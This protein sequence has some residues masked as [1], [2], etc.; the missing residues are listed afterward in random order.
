MTRINRRLFVQSTAAF[1]GLDLLR[2]PSALAADGTLTIAL[3]NN[4]STLDPIQTSNHDAMAISN[5]IF[6]NLLE[7]DLDGNIVPSLARKLPEINDDA[8]RFAFDLRDDVVFQNGQKFTAEDVKYSYEYMLDPKNRSIRR[9]L[10]SPIKEI[11][12]ESPTRVVFNLSGPYRPWL[13]YM[14]KFM[15]V[16]PKGSREAKGDDTFKS[17]PV[18]LGTGPGI[19]V[20]WQPDTQLELRRNPNYWRKGVP[21]WSRVVAKI[22]PDDATRLAYLMTKQADIISS[23]PPRDFDRLKST[24]GIQTGSKVAIGGMWFMQTNTKRAPFDDVNFRKAVS[25]AIDRRAFIDG[26]QAGLGTPIGSHFSPMDLGYLD[27][28]KVYPYDPAKARALLLEAGITAPLEVTLALPPPEYARRGGPLIAAQLAQVG[29]RAK[30]E[31]MEWDQWLAGPFKGNFDLTLINH[32]EPLDYATAY[33]NPDYYFGYDSA[34]IRGYAATLLAVPKMS[35]KGVLWRD[36]QRQ[37]TEDAV[38]VFIWNPAQVSVSRRGLRG[39][40]SSSPIIVNDM[41][42]VSWAPPPTK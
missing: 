5:A 8:T 27:L 33:A 34:K 19:F 39:L 38:N 25:H 21:A 35:D 31:N 42:A 23:P 28:T 10:F 14:T 18:G 26:A 36:I 32:V 13:Q 1:A 7:V 24:P 6:E 4:P 15:G 37:I 3:P 2:L 17:A 16:F 20:E 9:T 11:V 41:A 12:I 22:V 40:W 29:I 30:I